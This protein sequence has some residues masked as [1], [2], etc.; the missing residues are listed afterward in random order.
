MLH[1]VACCKW[2]IDEAYIRRGAGEEVDLSAVDWKISD[3][4][5]HALEEA[6]RLKESQGAK[7]TVLTVGD[8]KTA[9]GMKDMLSRGADEGCL[10]ADK[11]FGDLDSATTADLMVSAIEKHLSPYDLI[12]FGE[13]S[14]DLYAR[15]VG[16]RVAAGLK[17]PCLTGVRRIAVGEG[18]VEAERSLEGEIELVRAPLPA[19]LTVLPE[20]NA[21]RI[22][23]VKETLAAS[24]KPVMHLKS[25]DLPALKA[26]SIRTVKIKAAQLKRDCLFLDN[27][28]EGVR[29]LVE[30][31]KKKGLNF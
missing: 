1:I 30:E 12:L 23:G 11:A 6:V 22:P 20:I 8:E 21:P 19:A 16:P 26:P 4:D 10:V 2:V 31:L 28:P 7:V 15:Q 9:K 24:R 29:I 13:G 27:T 18:Y 17:I 25:S 3:Y 14:S 5:R